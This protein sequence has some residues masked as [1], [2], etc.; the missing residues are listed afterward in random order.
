[1]VGRFLFPH[2]NALVS[3]QARFIFLQ[4]SELGIG[5]YPLVLKHSNGDGDALQTATLDDNKMA[6]SPQEG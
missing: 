1:L 4:K 5:Q 6:H 3:E 2:I